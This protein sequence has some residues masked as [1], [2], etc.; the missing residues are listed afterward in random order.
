MNVIRLGLQ[1]GVQANARENRVP[2]FA[3]LATVGVA[4]SAHPLAEVAH[5]PW[6]SVM[7]TTTFR[8]RRA[9][10]AGAAAKADRK[11]RLLCVTVPPFYAQP[12]TTGS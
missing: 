2:S 9:A 10:I 7:K 1:T 8:R 5:G 4:I 6:S 3:S 11:E 12:A